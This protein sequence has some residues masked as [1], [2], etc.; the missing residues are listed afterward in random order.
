MSLTL[1]IIKPD[2]V[3]AGSAGKMLAQ[4]EEHGFTIRA[5]KMVHL[6]ASTP[7]TRSVPSSP[8]WCSS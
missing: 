2:A 4:L 7:S 8:T 6:T 5:L 3:G 1:G